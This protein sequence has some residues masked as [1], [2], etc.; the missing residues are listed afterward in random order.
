MIK[1]DKLGAYECHLCKGQLIAL[2]NNPL[3]SGKMLTH[4]QCMAC[5][6][7]HA[8]VEEPYIHPPERRPQKA[9]KFCG[10]PCDYYSLADDW[11]DYWKCNSCQV[12]YSEWLKTLN[13]PYGESIEI[14]TQIKGFKFC[15][16]QYI[17]ENKSR[18]EQV[19]ND[20]EGTLII[21]K[22]FDHLFPDVTPSNI[23]EKLPIYI[24]FS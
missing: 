9:C 11:Q 17:T 21:I 6:A 2:S 20:P 22:N 7:D 4:F 5:Q 15:L 24:L 10:Q 16:R 12:H 8:Y 18:L 14:Y 23:Q 1:M 13:E 19:P 3:P